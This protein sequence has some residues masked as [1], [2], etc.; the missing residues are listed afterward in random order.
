MLEE[1]YR[2]RGLD[3]RGF[4]AAEV[5]QRFGLEDVSTSLHGSRW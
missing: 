2:L 4:P 1:F 3:E 5:L